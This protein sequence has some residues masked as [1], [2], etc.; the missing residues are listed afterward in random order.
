MMQVQ[1]ALHVSFVQDDQPHLAPPTLG[2]H[3]THFLR[4]QRPSNPNP[5]FPTYPRT[6]LTAASAVLLLHTDEE[7]ECTTLKKFRAAKKRCD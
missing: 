7:S 5:L 1:E 4:P 3:Y 2:L 6:V